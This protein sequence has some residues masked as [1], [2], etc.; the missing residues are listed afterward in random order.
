MP[1]TH[2]NE[3]ALGTPAPSFALADADGRIWTPADALGTKGLLVAFL[4]NRCPYVVHIREAF[5]AYARDYAAKGI[6]VIAINSNDDGAYP[7][8]SAEAV[9]IE[10][11]TYGYAFPYLKDGKQEVARAYG[12]ACT[13]D[14]YLFDGEQKLFYHG[15]FDDSRP[16]NDL[17]VTGVDL[18]AATEA[19]L[20]GV[21]RPSEQKQAIGCNIKWL[22]GHEPEWFG[23]ATAAA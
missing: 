10:A 11:E 5:A 4:S 22:P 13:P 16:K 3:I 15:Q 2:S 8:E 14:L 21:E 12:A 18:R 23:A 1:L 6:R 17:P 9:R 20:A 19:I 7:E